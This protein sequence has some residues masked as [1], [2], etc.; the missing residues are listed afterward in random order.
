MA[1]GFVT[2]DERGRVVV[3]VAY[4]RALGLRTGS[5]LLVR[6]EAEGVHLE[7]PEQALARVRRLVRP[8]L[9][10]KPSAAEELLSDRAEELEG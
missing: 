9:E 10:G 2:I 1:V 5:R 4:R 6:L 7:T 8:Y 3:P